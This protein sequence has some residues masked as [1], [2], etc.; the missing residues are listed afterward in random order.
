[1]SFYKAFKTFQAKEKK[2]LS[3]SYNQKIPLSALINVK[4]ETQQATQ[5]GRGNRSKCN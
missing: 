3:H 5:N 1:M 2:T 4:I